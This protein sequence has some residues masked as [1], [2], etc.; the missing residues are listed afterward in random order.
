MEGM[1]S[2]TMQSGVKVVYVGD[3][4]VRQGEVAIIISTW[5]KRALM[6]RTPISER[7]IKARFYSK[8]KRLT[9]IQTYAPTNDALNEEKD[10][11]YNQLQDTISSCNKHDMIVLM[12]D[13]NAKTGS[14][15]ANRE[16]VMGKFVAGV[17]NENGRGYVTFVVQTD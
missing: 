7:I 9:V 14:N 13:L 6:E 12:G 10:E 15:N 5:A 16:E 1:G 2:R 3:E 8:Y 17:M 11:F 4:E